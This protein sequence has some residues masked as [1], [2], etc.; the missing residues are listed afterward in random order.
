MSVIQQIQDPAI[1]EMSA[2]LALSHRAIAC[3]KLT[4]KTKQDVEYVQS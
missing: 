2:V 4:I 1:K 3:S